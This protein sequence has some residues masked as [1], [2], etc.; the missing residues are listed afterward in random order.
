MN[1]YLKKIHKRKLKQLAGDNGECNLNKMV[2]SGDIPQEKVIEVW[3][4]MTHEI[5][6]RN[7]KHVEQT[8]ETLKVKNPEAAEIVK[9]EY[10]RLLN[11]I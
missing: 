10:E 4:K 3:Q 7:P 6:K 2:A 9:A 5:Y 1:Q 11:E 8:I